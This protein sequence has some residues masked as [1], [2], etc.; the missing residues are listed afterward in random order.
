MLEGAAGQDR[1]IGGP[2]NDKLFAYDGFRD[3]V[4]G[5]PGRDYGRLDSKDKAVTIEAR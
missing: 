3:L 2:G 1:L 4:E 5:G